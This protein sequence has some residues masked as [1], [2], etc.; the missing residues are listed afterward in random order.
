[1]LV[2]ELRE[3]DTDD[4]PVALKDVE[5]DVVIVPVTV[6]VTVAVPESVDDV[7]MVL[8]TVDDR[9]D[10]AEIEL[11]SDGVGVVDSV[12]FAD[13]DL[14]AV[15]VTVAV[16]ETETDAD[17]DGDVVD[18]IVGEVEKVDVDESVNWRDV[19]GVDD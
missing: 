3:F 7:E 19:V 10:V 17:T 1:M 12:M 14:T 6:A 5:I 11:E 9:D 4:V 13:A 2:D 8:D 15:R 16:A 18:V